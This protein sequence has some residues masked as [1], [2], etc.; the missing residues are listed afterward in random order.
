ML[1]LQGQ[2]R[3]A[4]VGYSM[5]E[6][7][8]K[9][10]LQIQRSRSHTRHPSCVPFFSSMV[11]TTTTC[12]SVWEHASHFWIS[13]ATGRSC[14]AMSSSARNISSIAS[15]TIHLRRPAIGLLLRAEAQTAQQDYVYN[16]DTETAT[17]RTRQVLGGMDVGY[18]FGTTGELRLGYEGGYEKL[19]PQIGNAAVLPTVSGATGDARLQYQLNTLDNAGDPPLRSKSSH[20]HQGLQHQSSGSG[21]VSTL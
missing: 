18:G 5:V 14:A 6:K 20:V 17:Y 3:F 13:A 16:G 19:S 8:G 21:T 7:H 15:T 11:P 10:G 4:N 1:R 2:G 12:F 9:Q